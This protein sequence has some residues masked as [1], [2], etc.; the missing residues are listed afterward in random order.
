[1]KKPTIEIQE[2]LKKPYPEEAVTL[3][4]KVGE[5]TPIPI[6][7]DVGLRE[8]QMFN[9]M[10]H[11]IQHEEPLVV[12]WGLSGKLADYYSKV[13]EKETSMD[14]VNAKIQ[15]ANTQQP[16]SVFRMSNF[17]VTIEKMGGMGGLHEIGFEEAVLI[18]EGKKQPPQPI[19]E[20]P[21]EAEFDENCTDACQPG[22]HK[23]GK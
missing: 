12:F 20:E 18:I 22:D 10:A 5:S 3:P 15:F 6:F 19:Y 14:A 16:F 7:G 4:F 2:I 17:E 13:D 21:E 8:L 11:K 1:M 23:C 9:D